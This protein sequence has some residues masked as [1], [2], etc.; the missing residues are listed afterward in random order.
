M[1]QSHDPP[2]PE[3]GRDKSYY[4]HVMKDFHEQYDAVGQTS[5]YRENRMN[6][7][8]FT[9]I[10][11]TKTSAFLINAI[12][13]HEYQAQTVAGVFKVVLPV[14]MNINILTKIV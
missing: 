13:A 7:P 10:S 12:L 3:C 2:S 5:Q 6:T 4:E 1:A 14:K 9:T 11:C 8:T